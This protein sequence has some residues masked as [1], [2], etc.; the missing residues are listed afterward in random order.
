MYKIFNHE[1]INQ[2]KKK[3]PFYVY[4]KELLTT[5]L[6]QCKKAAKNHLPYEVH[7]HYATKAN[8]NEKILH[9]VQEDGF[10]VD[11][12]SGGEIKKTLKAKFAAENTVFAGVGK[13]DAEIKFAR[14]L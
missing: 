9:L 14:S 11:C 3:T 12:V 4:D 8:D 6:A 10:G 5:T 7:L 1:I 13:T 2:I